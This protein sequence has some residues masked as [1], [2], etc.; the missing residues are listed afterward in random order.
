MSNI[1]E[2]YRKYIEMLST[3]Y[4]SQEAKSLVFMLLSE[5]FGISRTDLLMQRE[6]AL[7]LAELESFI[8]R[9]KNHE[10]IQHI[11]GRAWF[12]GLVLKVTA[13]TL[14]PRPETEEL[15]AWI[16]RAEQH[17]ANGVLIDV[18]TGTGCIPLA[19]KNRMPQLSAWGLDISAAALEVARDNQL[20][21]GLEIDLQQVDILTESL[22]VDKVDILVSNPPY[23]RP[24]EKSL[25]SGNVLDYEPHSALFIPE[26]DPLLFYRRIA[27]LGR[28]HLVEGGSLYFEI[29]EAFGEETARLLYELG[30]ASIELRKDM[31]GKDRML[32]GVK[33]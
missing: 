12:D 3:V 4:P 28:E 10:P 24:S 30:Y 17:R 29:N 7:D 32:R 21:A 5:G 20:E 22:P 9:L 11:L 2:I 31:Q 33:Q 27:V 8:G 15:V 23:V 6:V 14:I 18:G 13:N 1:E 26:A 25:M 16:G 19:L